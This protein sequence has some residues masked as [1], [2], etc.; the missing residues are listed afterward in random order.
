M[1]LG[2]VNWA[3][4]ADY[5]TKDPIAVLDFASLY[6]TIIISK[7]LCYSTL[8]FAEDRKH[9]KPN[10]LT[11]GETGAGNFYFVKEHVNFLHNQK[12]YRYKSINQIG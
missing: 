1:Q 11:V 8:L 4:E 2:A 7:N 6:P 9:F 12:I 10:D 5:Y 3:P